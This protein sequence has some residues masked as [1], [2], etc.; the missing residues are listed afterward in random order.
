MSISYLDNDWMGVKIVEHF[1]RVVG[2][3]QGSYSKLQAWGVKIY[4]YKRKNDN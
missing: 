1:Q 4:R 3:L 2:I